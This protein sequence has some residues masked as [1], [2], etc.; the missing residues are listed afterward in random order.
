MSQPCHNH[1]TAMSSQPSS[2]EPAMSVTSTSPPCRHSRRLLSQPCPSPPRVTHRA[3]VGA[4][5]LREEAQFRPHELRASVGRREAIVI[6]MVVVSRGPPRRG[7]V[8]ASRGPNQAGEWGER[9]NE[10]DYDRF[11][12]RG[13]G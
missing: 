5:R 12:K 11:N 9:N 4:H 1:V 7:G 10:C 8:T 3:R 13:G 2:P 6:V